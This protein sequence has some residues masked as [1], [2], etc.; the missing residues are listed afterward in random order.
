MASAG[1]KVEE[2]C[3]WCIDVDKGVSGASELAGVNG[4]LLGESEKIKTKPFEKTDTFCK[5]LA[6]KKNLLGF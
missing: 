2:E 5:F 6:L 3:C 4:V 1:V